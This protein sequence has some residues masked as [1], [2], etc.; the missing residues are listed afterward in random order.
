MRSP[1]ISRAR[2][3]YLREGVLRGTVT[4]GAVPNLGLGLRI[5]IGGIHLV[6]DDSPFVTSN[7]TRHFI[8]SYE[9]ELLPLLGGNVEFRV[10]DTKSLES[11]LLHQVPGKR[12][13]YSP[14]FMPQP[15]TTTRQLYWWREHL[16]P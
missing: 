3:R 6:A 2:S 7:L 4:W 1:G 13:Q 14:F 12:R 11:L 9:Y 5:S 16:H 15:F 10:T 8:G